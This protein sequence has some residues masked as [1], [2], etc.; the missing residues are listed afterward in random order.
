MARRTKED[1]EKTRRRILKAALDIF[2][3]KGY[4]KATFENIAKRINLSKGAV[5]WHFSNKPEL[6]KQLIVYII[7]EATGKQRI[8]NSQPDNLI[9]LRAGLKEWMNRVV[10]V[11]TNRKH[12]RMLLGLDWSRPALRGVGAQFKKLDNSLI[13]VIAAAL[14]V[15]QERGALRSGVDIM[16][17]AHTIV[18][19]WI[20]ILHCQLGVD[21][22]DYEVDAV[23]D[24]LMDSIECNICAD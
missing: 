23:L 18:L 16:N 13:N 4:D 20:G 22:M 2:S 1:A 19:T 24:F 21:D 12:I 6:L 3:K 9:E 5:Y 14:R 7:D 11:P 10:K 15:M 8:I 17:V